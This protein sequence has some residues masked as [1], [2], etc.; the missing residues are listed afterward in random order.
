[1][2]LAVLL[3]FVVVGTFAAIRTFNTKLLRG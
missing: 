1:V 3:G 2:H